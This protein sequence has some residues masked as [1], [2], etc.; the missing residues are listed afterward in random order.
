MNK[1][2]LR[3]L[4]LAGGIVAA[5]LLILL[6]SRFFRAEGAMVEVRVNGTLYGTYSLARETTVDIDGKCTL[7]IADGAAS[8]T[9]A[10]C[11]NRICVAHA[12]IRRAGEMIVCLPNG[13]TVRVLGDEFDFVG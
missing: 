5:A 10:D 4:L 1:K 8:I 12:P 3:D 2:I 9:D 6:F 13:V 11:K 7:M